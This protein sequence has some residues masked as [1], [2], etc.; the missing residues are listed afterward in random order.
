LRVA[1]LDRMGAPHRADGRVQRPALR[2]DRAGARSGPQ[3]ALSMEA[4][5]HPPIFHLPGIPDHVTYTWLSMIILTSVAFAASR[6]V[7]LVPLDRRSKAGRAEVPQA[8]HGARALV[9]EAPDVR[10]RNHQPS[11]PPAVTVVAALRQH[12]GRAHPAGG[13]LL[14]DGV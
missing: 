13:H 4:I 9:A 10:D 6:N 3:G 7:R 12:D 5:E 8:L 11:R 14:P 2:R 1:P